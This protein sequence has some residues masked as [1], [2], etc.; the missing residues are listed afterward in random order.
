MKEYYYLRGVERCGPYSKEEILGK[1]LP[2]ST[3]L[4]AEGME[5]WKTISEIPELQPQLKK[6]AHVTSTPNQITG[7]SSTARNTEKISSKT[8]IV[9]ISWISFHLFALLMCETKINFFD[10]GD[11]FSDKAKFWP[12]VNYVHVYT[13]DFLGIFNHYDITEF[14]LYT[15][16]SI[17]IYIILR[18]K[19][20]G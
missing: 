20:K 2:S 12:F 14:A 8:L 3:L 1:R 18:V 19:I 11:D 9:L 15:G 7:N 4:W 10:N 13:H 16:I 6:E 5:S 17:F